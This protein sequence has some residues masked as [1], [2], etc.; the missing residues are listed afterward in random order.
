MKLRIISVFF[1]FTISFSISDL[2]G[3]RLNVSTSTKTEFVLRGSI[4]EGEKTASLFSAKNEWESFQVFLRSNVPIKNIDFEISNLSTSKGEIIDNKNIKIY[5]EYYMYLDSPTHLNPHEFKKAWYPDPLIPAKH[6]LT[7]APLNG[8]LKAFPFTLPANQTHAVLV[9]IYTPKTTSAG[10]YTGSV[11]IKT[12]G[13]VI[14]E[15]PIS[16]QVWN[17]T[18]PDVFTLKNDFGPSTL[19]SV[20]D[21]AEQQKN[22]QFWNDV[23]HQCKELASRH[24]LIV[25]PDYGA[26]F[27]EKQNDGSYSVSQE[28]IDSL[29]RLIDLYDIN[30]LRVPTKYSWPGGIIDKFKDPIQ[31][32]AELKAFFKAWDDVL[33]QIKD[34][35]FL[36]YTYLF[37]EP[38]N[39]DAYNLVRKWGKEI[40][41][42]NSNVEMLV[43][44]QTVT[45][46]ENWGNL[47][48][49]V[50]IWCPHFGAYNQESANSRVAE[51]EQIWAYTFHNGNFRGNRGP[52]W[53][54]DI[55]TLL[56]CRVFSWMTWKYRVSGV[57]Y[58]SS[59]RAVLTPD[60]WNNPRTYRQRS[61]PKNVYN[62]E[63]AL[64]YP[65]DTVGYTGIVPSLR[66]KAMRDA[67]EDHEYMSIIEKAGFEEFAQSVIANLVGSWTEWDKD[68]E[69][70]ENARKKLGDFI[71]EKNLTE[72]KQPEELEYDGFTVIKSYP[73]PMLHNITFELFLNEKAEVEFEV[74]DILGRCVFKDYRKDLQKGANLLEYSNSKLQL[75]VGSYL[76]KFKAG[77]QK[78]M[79]RII[80]Q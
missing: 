44:E 43:V 23:K 35:D 13:E 40:R 5:R 21:F 48:G 38:N 60:S 30:R 74:F 64:Y 62:G 68:P 59:T 9:D 51:G 47:Y 18:L 7:N 12:E 4:H 27:A 11:S 58:W 2:M 15:V 65:A 72:T 55:G 70:Y 28:M 22:P 8:K 20:P 33:P 80:K 36:L 32:Q 71:E 39:A 3:Q 1:L 41:K 53:T 52:S 42:F 73:N 14:E 66:L 63:A 77:E 75:P 31:N 54:I 76:C 29:N 17:F 25:N 24:K 19:G 37:D 79:V 69:K 26:I 50:D 6:P 56:D 34:P 61:R 16:L 46:D 78:G 10:T 67:F 49:A 45:Q 57:L